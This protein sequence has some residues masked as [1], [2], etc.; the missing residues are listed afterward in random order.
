MKKN[1]FLLIIFIVFF[2][3]AGICYSYSI[4]NEEK[5]ATAIGE[6]L[7]KECWADMRAKNLE[8]L[9]KMMSPAFQSV[10]QDRARNY[11]EEIE[12]I[13]GLNMG[14]FVLSNFK[15]TQAGPVITVTYTAIVEE[16]IKGKR[17]PRRSSVRLSSWIKTEEGWKWLIHANFNPLK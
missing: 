9:E 4:S 17:L 13:K 16:T 15:V 2:I 12:L 7:V 11:K 6:E 8:K 1:N 3:V 5:E 14:N 10:H